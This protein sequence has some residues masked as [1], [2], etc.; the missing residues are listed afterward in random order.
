MLT[1]GSLDELVSTWKFYGFPVVHGD[2]MLVGY[3]TRDQIIAYLGR[4][5]SPLCFSI[6][7][8]LR[9]RRVCEG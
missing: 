8:Q 9:Y 1:L 6:P 3:V 2:G 4:C 7:T 5:S